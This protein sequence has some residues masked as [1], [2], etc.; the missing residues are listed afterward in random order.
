M[1]KGIISPIK[2]DESKITNFESFYHVITMTEVKPRRLKDHK[3]GK[4]KALLLT[5]SFFAELSTV[6]KSPPFF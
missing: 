1:S 4:I 3:K 6:T 2:E 5:K